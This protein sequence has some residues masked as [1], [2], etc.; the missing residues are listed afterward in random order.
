MT[1]QQKQRERP[2]Q[3][4]LAVGVRAIVTLDLVIGVPLALGLLVALL[5][6]PTPRDGAGYFF[7]VLMFLLV[8]G[9]NGAGICLLLRHHVLARALQWIPTVIMLVYIG[10]VFFIT[11]KNGL[12]SLP[13][14]LIVGALLIALITLALPLLLCKLTED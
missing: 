14:P 8:F 13:L 3:P 7:G 6:E 9:L 2:K 4:E 5:K 12:A 10:I 11:W 1:Q